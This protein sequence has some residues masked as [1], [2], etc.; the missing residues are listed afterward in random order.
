M[1]RWPLSVDWKQATKGRKY[2]SEKQ[3]LLTIY[4]QLIKTTNNSNPGFLVQKALLQINLG[5]TTNGYANLITCIKTNPKSQLAAQAAGYLLKQH[6]TF[7]NW[8]DFISTVRIVNKYRLGTTY[9]INK[10]FS[11][12]DK[13]AGV[14]F[15]SGKSLFNKGQ[16][17]KSIERFKELIDNYKKH[18]KREEGLFLLA[19]AYNKDK[20]RIYDLAALKTLIDEYPRTKRQ[21]KALMI[22][23]KWAIQQKQPEYIYFFYEKYLMTFRSNRDI[24]EIRKI[25]VNHY[26]KN[27]HYAEALQKLKDQIA[28]IRCNRNE[29]IR[30]ALTYMLIEEKYGDMD[31]GLWASDLVLKLALNDDL[32]KARAL[33]FKA[34]IAQ[35]RGDLNQLIQ[36]E[37]KFTSLRGQHK[38][39]ND[40]LGFI[41]FAIIEMTIKPIVNRDHIISIKNPKESVQKYF[42]MFQSIK[43]KYEIVCFRMNM[44]CA[45]AKI[46]IASHSAAAQKAISVIKIPSSL[47]AKTVEN[48]NLYKS[49]YLIKLKNIQ[50]NSNA[51][52]VNL[53]KQGK[54][55]KKWQSDILRSH[56]SLGH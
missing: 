54:T 30:S 47:G 32:A 29:K 48:F 22:G 26:M 42:T 53:A 27:G 38:E 10:K 56:A 16:N 6:Y 52:A 50:F 4:N 5:S 11:W 51:F 28:D 31:L 40:H 49:Q 15:N 55:T 43:K 2:I 45:S 34:R 23:G 44:Y 41:R 3:K 20:N 9:Y 8:E 12:K 7:K 46:R 18:N 21:R 14:L 36:L 24:P 39:I 13:M 33:G 37:K 19:H 1:A 35:R 25:L 17:K